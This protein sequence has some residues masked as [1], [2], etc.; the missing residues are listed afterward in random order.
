MANQLLKVPSNGA[1][2]LLFCLTA[3]S[4]QLRCWRGGDPC[5]F[6]E[7]STA[8]TAA[9]AA[10]QTAALQLLLAHGAGSKDTEWMGMD[11]LDVAEAGAGLEEGVARRLFRCYERMNRILR[12][13]S[14]RR[15]AAHAWSAGQANMPS[16][17]GSAA[18]NA[19]RVL[20]RYVCV[21]MFA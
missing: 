2:P 8:L 10:G 21:W 20:R 14:C 13:T 9:L 7:G 3:T 16:S 19:T 18:G 5:T 17:G 6:A 12:A 4:V 15:K 11:P 1:N